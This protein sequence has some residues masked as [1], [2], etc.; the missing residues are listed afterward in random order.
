MYFLT[1]AKAQ[2]AKTTMVFQLFQDH[3]LVVS[4]VHG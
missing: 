1:L 2:A 3:P 4:T